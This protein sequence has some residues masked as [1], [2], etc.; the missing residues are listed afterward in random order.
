L[1]G[2][3]KFLKE[4]EEG[5]SY[6]TVKHL[7]SKTIKEIRFPLPPLDEQKRIVAVLDQAFAALDRARANAEANRV[8]SEGFFSSF[9]QEQ[10]DESGGQTATLQQLMDD[11]VILGHLDGNHGSEYPRKEEFVSSGVPYISA[12]CIVGQRIDFSRAKFLSVERVARIRKG[13][14]K[15]GDVLFAHNATVGPVAILRTSSE[16]VVLG[17]SLTYYRCNQSKVLPEFLMYEMRAA[18]FRSQY[19]AVMKQATR[20]QVPI[21][22]QRTFTHC[23]PDL[24]AQAAIVHRCESAGIAAREL[25]RRYAEDIADIDAVRQSLLQTA[26]TGQLTGTDDIDFDAPRLHRMPDPRQGRDV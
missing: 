18:G 11:G 16:R 6:T 17:T 21:T 20:S 5:T 13:V 26:F 1:Y 25:G 15:D 4:I 3:N 8:D 7:S 23:I 10:L 9:V 19:E 24:E 14:A 2:I 22:M 12:N